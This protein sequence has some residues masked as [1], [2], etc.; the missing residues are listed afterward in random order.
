MDKEGQAAAVASG[1]PG[2]AILR[3]LE[4]LLITLRKSSKDLA[5]YPPGHPLLNRSLERAAEQLHSVVAV[6]APLSLAV[7]RS[8]FTFEG[9]PV[10]KE[11]RQLASMAAELFVRRVQKIFFAQEVGPEELAGFL[12]MITSD[13]KQLVQQGGPAKVLAAHGVGRIQV[14]EFDF[15]RV[16]TAAGAAGRAAG[17]G[18]GE[19]GRPG[20]AGSG[21]GPGP[22][23]SGIGPGAPGTAGGPAGGESAAGG[24]TGATASAGAGG[25]SPPGGMTS[26]DGGAASGILQGGQAAGLQGEG[27]VLT[28]GEGAAGQGLP[29]ASEGGEQAGQ[30]PVKPES[31]ITAPGSQKELT[32]E[33]LIQR[34][35]QEGASGDV[36]GYEGAASRLEKA[37]GQAVHDDWLQDVL[38]ILRVFLR[39]Q[40]AE[41]LKAS[42]RERAAQAVETASGGNTG[43]YLIEH[44]RTEE[45]ES[46]RDLSAVLVRLGARVIPPLLRRLAA[47][48]QEE[49]RERLAATLV[50]FY[51]A[52]EPDVTQVLQALDRDQG[53]HLAPILGEI[54]GKAGAALL[55][56]LFRHQ[57][58]QVRGE[59]LRVLGGFDEPAAQ[60]LLVQALRDPDPAV[61]E[62]AV[63]LVGAVKLKLATPTLLRLAGQRVLS[64]KPFAVRKAAVTALGA[65]GD[66]G[67]IPMLKRMLYTR[68]WFQR[69]AGDEL[70]QAAALALLSMGR[71]EA[72]EVVVGGARS[73]RGDVRRV[74]TAAL[75]STPAEEHD[76]HPRATG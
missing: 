55:A 68:A 3:A 67:A 4:N 24:P 7:S 25:V 43:A 17:G 40:R 76:L 13:P 44:L 60:R 35:E 63:G 48:N 18:T 31:L 58:T 53:C 23:G 11:N 41:N 39:H 5:F 70:R 47:E 56:S 66:A 1:A 46:A 36:A 32:V 6:R 54:G 72:G 64:G 45:G 28:P 38:A 73:G 21:Q 2:P 20:V 62:V 49:V 33:A 50:R 26:P 37:V 75:R 69:A 19:A 34:L 8:G 9:Q 14:N 61:L 74:C 16:G 27:G 15:R 57:D 42:L 65:M 10:G 52:A 29:A 59:A 30:G 12:R 51:E 22:G 71:P